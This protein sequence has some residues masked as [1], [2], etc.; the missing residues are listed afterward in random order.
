MLFDFWHAEKCCSG[1]LFWHAVLACCSNTKLKPTDKMLINAVLAFC[2]GMLFKHPVQTHRQ[3]PVQTPS[4]NP[5]N[6]FLS[7]QPF[8]LP[9]Q[10]AWLQIKF[11]HTVGGFNT[12]IFC[13]NSHFVSQFNQKTKFNQTSSPTVRQHAHGYR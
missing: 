10:T 7:K 6:H 13:P 5:N 9:V 11:T 3:H 8:C 1:M 2:S 12:S 4:S